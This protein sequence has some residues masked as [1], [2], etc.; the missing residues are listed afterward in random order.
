VSCPLK[1]SPK[2]ELTVKVT[3]VDTLTGRSF[4][5]QTVVPPRA[6]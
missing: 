3:F 6:E 5:Q 2:G 1:E 4:S